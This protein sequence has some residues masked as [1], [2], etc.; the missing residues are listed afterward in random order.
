MV[1]PIATHTLV[2]VTANSTGATIDTRGHHKVTMAYTVS[3]L[4][5]ASTLALEG[6]ADGENWYAIDSLINDANGTSAVYDTS[7]HR[8]VRAKLSSY[9]NGTYDVWLVLSG[10]AG[11]GGWAD[12]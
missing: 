1:R 6:S 9:G 2:G 8:Y 12:N 3:G 7:I 4:T 10:H 5:L 11:S